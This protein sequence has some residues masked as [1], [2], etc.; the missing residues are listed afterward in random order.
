[1]VVE[2]AEMGG[3]RETCAEHPGSYFSSW[4]EVDEVD[5]PE[6]LNPGCCEYCA[7]DA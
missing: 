3:S 7:A 4:S 6:N 1:M 2:R 5:L